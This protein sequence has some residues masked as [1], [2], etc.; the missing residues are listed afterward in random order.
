MLEPHGLTTSI[1]EGAPEPLSP[2]EPEAAQPPSTEKDL[3]A[4]DGHAR[5]MA[6]PYPERW[7][8]AQTHQR[9]SRSSHP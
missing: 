1:G 9:D 2:S 3:G 7:D 8:P 5:L 4:E 6:S